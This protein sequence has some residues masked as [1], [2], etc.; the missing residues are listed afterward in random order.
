MRRPERRNR[1]S[2]T[3]DFGW[4]AQSKMRVPEPTTDR[5]GEFRNNIEAIEKA[6]VRE[7]LIQG[8]EITLIYEHPRHDAGYTT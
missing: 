2:G 8:H 5:Y 7:L 1:K 3:K 4:R 6:V